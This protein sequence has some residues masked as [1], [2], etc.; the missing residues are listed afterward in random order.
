[1]AE[2]GAKDKIIETVKNA[3]DE[4]L[5]DLKKLNAIIRIP[6]LSHDFINMTRRKDPKLLEQ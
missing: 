2:L 1:M 3:Y 5:Y 4:N 6:K